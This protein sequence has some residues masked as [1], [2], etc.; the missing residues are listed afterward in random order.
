VDNRG[1][2]TG[3]GVFSNMEALGFEILN[4]DEDG[5]VRGGDGCRFGD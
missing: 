1:D 3:V 2:V 4:G 5:A